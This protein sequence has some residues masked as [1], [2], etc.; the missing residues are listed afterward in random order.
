M[1]VIEEVMYSDQGRYRCVATNMQAGGL[2]VSENSLYGA[3]TVIRKLGLKWNLSCM[4]PMGP[5][6]IC[7]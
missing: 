5:E 1:F 7:K 3:L 2:R 4:D 6:L